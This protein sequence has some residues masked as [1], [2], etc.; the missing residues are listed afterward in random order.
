MR[1]LGHARIT[2]DAISAGIA[3]AAWPA[4]LQRLTAGPLAEAARARG[5][6][7]WLDGGHN[8]HAARALADALGRMQARDGRPT[9]L[10][11]GLLANKDAAEWFEAF[12]ALAPRVLTVGGYADAAAEAGVLAE[13][14][15]VQGLTPRLRTAWTPL[16]RGAL[17]R[18]RS[19]PGGHRRIAVPGGEVLARSPATWPT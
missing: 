5:A 1:A 14:A 3:A 15:N 19:A 10:I 12:G 16:W 7:L 2:A 17:R 11:A 18:R 13:A 6:D 4:R 8:P 9:V